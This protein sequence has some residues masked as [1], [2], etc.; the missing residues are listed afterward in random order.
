MV[1][2]VTPGLTASQALNGSSIVPSA[3]QRKHDS[4]DASPAHAGQRT[5]TRIEM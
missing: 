2:S 1:P 4:E 5:R 3:P